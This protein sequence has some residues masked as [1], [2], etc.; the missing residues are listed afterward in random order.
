MFHLV[1]GSAYFLLLVPC[2]VTILTYIILIFDFIYIY[3]CM[4]FIYLS[5]CCFFS[6]FIHM[7]LFIVCN[8]LNLFHTKM[9]WWVLFKVFQKYRLSKSTC[10]KLS[11]CKVFQEFVLYFIV[12][13][14]W[15]WV[16]WFMTFLICSFVCCDFV[17]DCQ[18]GRLLE[19]KW[20]I[21]RNIC[22]YFM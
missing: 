7:F 22:H 13:N 16:E 1:R 9:S 18:R 3:W 14:K 5:M 12:F 4:L 11:S 6:L 21:V 10:H 15:V 19:H 2:L 17:T 20:F 8:L